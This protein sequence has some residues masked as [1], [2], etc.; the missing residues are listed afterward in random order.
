MYLNEL[1]KLLY[2]HACLMEI[3]STKIIGSNPVV[4]KL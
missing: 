1:Y 2:S 4:A 3:L